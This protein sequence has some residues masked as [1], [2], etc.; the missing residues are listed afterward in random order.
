MNNSQYVGFGTRFYAAFI[1]TVICL[2]IILGIYYLIYGTII[3]DSLEEMNFSNIVI[4]YIFPFIV[5]LIFWIYKSATPG[6]MLVKAVIVDATTYEKP[7]VK[8]LV[9]RNL[10]YYLSLLPLGLG[11]FWVIWDKRKQGWHDKLANTVV[12]QPKTEKKSIGFGGYLL[13]GLGI[14]LGVALSVAV[15]LGFM[16]KFNGIPDGNIYKAQ[17]LRDDVKQELLDKKLVDSIDE[18]LYLYAESTFS[19]TEEGTIITK[20]GIEVFSTTEEG[21]L[22]KDFFP[23]KEISSLKVGTLE[24]LNVTNFEYM[25][26]AF[27]FKTLILYLYNDEHKI[28]AYPIIALKAQE[29][30]SFEKEILGLWKK[31]RALK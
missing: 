3:P 25:E 24:D 28:F 27:H 26:D 15:F 9:I 5:T 12:I 1:D 17:N 18:L 16:I 8:Q 23:F 30:E 6:K 2:F 11:Y 7:S 29:K 31:A 21:E 19:F 10:G 14:F 20:Q 13:R 4:Q 22:V